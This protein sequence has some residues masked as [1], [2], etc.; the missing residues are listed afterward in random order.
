METVVVLHEYRRRGI[1]EP[2][3]IQEIVGVVVQTE[4]ETDQD[5]RRRVQETLAELR[6]RRISGYGIER[7]AFEG[8]LTDVW[9]DTL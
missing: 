9:T 7:A 4:G 3:D 2:E 5:F 1:K 8:T 6:A